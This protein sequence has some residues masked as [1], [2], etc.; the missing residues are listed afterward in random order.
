MSV[1]PVDAQEKSRIPLSDHVVG[2]LFLIA[3]T[4][5]VIAGRST[6]FVL[7]ALTLLA[8]AMAYIERVSWRTFLEPAPAS[9][10]VAVFLGFAVLSAAWSVDMAATAAATLSILFILFQWH[11][12][13]RWI[14]EQPA[15]RLHHVAFWLVIAF[16]IGLIFLLLEVFSKQYVRAALMETFS[17]FRP[18]SPARYYSI[19][20]AGN[21][22]IASFELNRSIAALNMILWPAI[23]C[24]LSSWT[25][26][27]FT[28]IAIALI[29]GTALATI[30]SDHET[31]KLALIV[32]GLCFLIAFYWRR[33]AYVGLAACWV[34][35]GIG[36]LPGAYFAHD[37]LALHQAPWLQSSAQH[38]IT[39]WDETADEALQDP[40]IGHGARAAYI[41]R[42]QDPKRPDGVRL[43]RSE[44][45]VAI[46]AHNVYLQNWYEFGAVGVLLFI[47]A[48]LMVLNAIR[49]IPIATQP[50]ALATFA[51][52][53][54]H[55]ASSYELWQSWF[56]SLFALTM[57]YLWW[58]IRAFEAAGETQRR[59]A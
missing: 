12:I 26:R 5:N 47:V 19:D 36:A 28:L 41:M 17:L 40:I 24:A 34:A 48:G 57:I 50:Y 6:V 42:Q 31:S 4:S 2:T 38:R 21:V 44:D 55:I 46:H 13:D 15:R 14:S 27:K 23:L 30:G 37:V 22:S 52:F 56:A 18:S 9:R 49:T 54:V 10:P 20:Q 39:I 16:A 58:G 33:T 1:M 43:E 7:P 51:S 45:S 29:A 59:L 11:I 8:L 3:A 32:S 35:L 53:A 25:G